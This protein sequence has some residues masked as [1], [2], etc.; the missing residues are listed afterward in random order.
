MATKIKSQTVFVDFEEYEGDTLAMVFAWKDS[1][2]V[3]TNLAGYS[4]K[5][6]IK[7]D[8]D[9]P[10]LLTLTDAGSITLGGTPNNLIV[11]L[12]PTQT[13]QLGTGSFVYDIEI[14]NSLGKVNTLVSG[15]ITLK[16]SVTQ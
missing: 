9:S 4:A 3:L 2:G 11:E 8:T 16:Q 15:K 7:V 1:S 12:T 13:K 10:S 5:M 14:T 6:D